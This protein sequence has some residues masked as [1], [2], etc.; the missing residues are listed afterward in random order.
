TTPN[1][2]EFEGDGGNA[3]AGTQV[4]AAVGFYAPTQLYT[5]ERELSEVLSFLFGAS[6]SEAVARA[7]SPIEYASP[8]FPPT[9]LITGN[10]DELVPDEAS[11]RMYEALS[12]AGAPVEL[13]VY[14]GAPH[15]FDAIPEFGRQ[16]ASIVSLFLDRYVASPRPVVVPEAAPAT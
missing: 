13:H 3:G 12:K 8:R 11:F 14:A 15:A 1:L 4:A 2:P 7:A 9:L 16:C 10:R 6:Y 5:P